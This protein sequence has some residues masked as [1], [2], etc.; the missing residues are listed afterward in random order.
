MTAAE[1]LKAQLE[2]RGIY[3]V[4]LEYRFHAVRRWRFDLAIPRRGVGVEIEGGIFTQGRHV[5][6]AGYKRDMQKY[7]EAAR[8][9]WRLLRFTPQDVK[10][11]I[12]VCQIIEALEVTE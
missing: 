6:G 1:M 12:A 11:G 4:E 9:G 2:Q 8:S 5:R 7:N 3:D 10:E